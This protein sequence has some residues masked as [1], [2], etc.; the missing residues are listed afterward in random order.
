[1]ARGGAARAELRPADFRRHR[2]GAA[3]QV[4][5]EDAHEEQ[6]RQGGVEEGQ[7]DRQARVSMIADA[8]ACDADRGQAKATNNRGGRVLKQGGY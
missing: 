4:A 8:C 6:E 7:R 3:P 5:G 2:G 1:M